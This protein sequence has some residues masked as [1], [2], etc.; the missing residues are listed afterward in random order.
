M[1]EA[2]IKLYR[3]GGWREA[4]NE[5]AYLARVVWRA[6]VDKR[7]AAPPASEEYEC[8]CLPSPDEDPETAMLQ[9][10][11]EERLRQLIDRLPEELRLPL[12]LSFR[13]ELNSRQI[14]EVLGIPE[15][16]VRTRQQR[17]RQLLKQ[18][19]LAMQAVA[20]TDG[21]L[22]VREAHHAG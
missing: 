7:R 22:P 21:E 10:T 8:D 17:A 19:F 16:T 9:S 15:G 4:R 1:Q 2:C 11:Q 5:R 13:E 18:K 20:D 6:A 12:V 14:G 3:H